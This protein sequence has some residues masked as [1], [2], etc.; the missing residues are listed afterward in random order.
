M[1]T[2]RLAAAIWFVTLPGL[3]FGTLGVLAPLRLY[4][5]GF[6][7]VAIGATWLISSGFEALVS[8]TVG[9][10]SDRIGRVRPILGGLTAAMLVLLLLPWPGNRFVLAAVVVC[11]GISFG[12]FWTP[13]MSMLSDAAEEQGLDYGYAFALV[14][15][16]WAP[17]QAAGAWTSGRV[18]AATAD[19]VPYLTLS[20]VCALTLA[21][22]WRSASSS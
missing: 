4:D 9:R 2:P 22:L 13:A 8:P 10:L 14:N 20:A 11:A 19:A 6:G 16:A 15:I 5:L 18:A 7:A 3:L 21:A 1:R 17:G 12:T